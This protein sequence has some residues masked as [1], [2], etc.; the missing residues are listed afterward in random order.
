MARTRSPV[1]G[2]RPPALP[3][4]VPGG[5]PQPERGA[6]PLSWAVRGGQL[7]SA[8]MQDGHMLKTPQTA[9][10]IA[11]DL[12][13]SG[14]SATTGDLLK[15]APPGAWCRCGAGDHRRDDHRPGARNFHARP[16]GGEH[17]HERHHPG[18]SA[19]CLRQRGHT[20]KLAGA[21][22]S[23]CLCRSCAGC[24]TSSAATGPA[25]ARVTMPHRMSRRSAF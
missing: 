16:P 12:G 2:V 5:G 23:R 18:R 15:H 25:I 19:V 13:N 22:W 4:Q 21:S 1:T 9:L 6:G 8:E 14:I 10:R 11:R 7:R 24:P 20:V 3:G 17:D